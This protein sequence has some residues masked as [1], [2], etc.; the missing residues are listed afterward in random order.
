MLQAVL[1]IIE[2]LNAAESIFFNYYNYL[3]S[4]K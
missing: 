4:L 2:F 1:R 3:C